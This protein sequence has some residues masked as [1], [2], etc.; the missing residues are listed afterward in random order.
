MA[1]EEKIDRRSKRSKKAFH[2]A[3]LKLLK[4]K[5][6]SKITVKE[7]AEKADRDRKTFY[8]HYDS[9]D[10]LIDEILIEEITETITTISE[11]S[12]NESGL[13]DIQ[14]LFINLFES[15]FSNASTKSILF[16]HVDTEKVVM[17]L[18]PV[19][20]DVITERNLFG[21]D[22]AIKPYLG[23]F[24]TYHCAGIIAILQQGTF[25]NDLSSPRLAELAG[26]A[27]LGGIEGLNK[28]VRTTDLEEVEATPA[29]NN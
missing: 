4:E 2:K 25:N 9:I 17:R 26:A 20:S 14:L 28:A 21:L 1:A 29:K 11:E 15:F 3:F 22:E 6:L 13:L 5:D 18:C 7:I 19:L 27:V 12:L 8:L 16:R 10:S 24:V 23:M